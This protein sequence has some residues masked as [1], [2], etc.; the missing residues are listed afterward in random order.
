MCMAQ[1]PLL[2][3]PYMLLTAGYSQTDWAC[4]QG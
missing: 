1:E 3:H 2:R 4:S